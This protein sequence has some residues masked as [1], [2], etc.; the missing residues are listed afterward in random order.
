MACLERADNH[1]CNSGVSKCIIQI[2][3]NSPCL[4]L[5]RRRSLKRSCVYALLPGWLIPTTVRSRRLLPLVLSPLHLTD[6]ATACRPARGGHAALPA[7]CSLR[8]WLTAAKMLACE[9]S[10]LPCRSDHVVLRYLLLCIRLSPP[11]LL[12]QHGGYLHLCAC[13][14]LA[15]LS[16]PGLPQ[17][18]SPPF[19]P[20]LGAACSKE[21]FPTSCRVCPQ[22]L[23]PPCIKRLN[24]VTRGPCS[25]SAL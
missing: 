25:C 16:Q 8:T 7:C 9:I 1:M 15:P 14:P 6:G 19:I 24:T 21:S 13:C 20:R 5:L 18:Q 4:M 11:A 23:C 17:G 3:N 12:S 22:S 10:L 2:I